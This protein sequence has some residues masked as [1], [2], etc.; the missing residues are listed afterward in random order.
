MW[1]IVSIISLIWTEDFI[2]LKILMI[3][4]ALITVV[5]EEM[6]SPSFAAF[7]SNPM[8]ESITIILSNLFQEF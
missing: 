7:K 4:K 8:S 1:K 5:A 3:L 2:N 6:L